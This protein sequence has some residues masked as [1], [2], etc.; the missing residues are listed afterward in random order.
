MRTFCVQCGSHFTETHRGDDV[1][2]T[3]RNR[4]KEQEREEQI[5]KEDEEIDR[6][7]E[8]SKN[9]GEQ[10]HN[11]FKSVFESWSKPTTQGEVK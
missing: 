5:R 6:K 9:R 10:I 11:F 4:W 7:E 8:L 2:P 3:C 1:C